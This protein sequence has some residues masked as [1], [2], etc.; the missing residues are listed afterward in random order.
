MN[1]IVNPATSINGEVEAPPSK[2][3]TQF[4][5]AIAIL[6]NGKCTIE[7]PLRVRDT[8]V[9]LKAAESLGAVVKRSQEKWSIW[10]LNG[11]IKSDKNNLDAKNSGTAICLLTALTTLSPTPIVLNGDSQLRSRPMP[12]FLKALRS[13]GADVYSTKPD[14]SP[15]FMVFGG[16]FTGGK[17]KL[18]SIESRYLPA[19]LVAAPYAKKKVELKLRD[20]PT[21]LVSELMKI[22][23]VKI[24]EKKN[25]LQI[26]NQAYRAFSYRIPQEIS[27]AAPFIVAASL[28]HS[29]IKI[30]YTGQLTYRDREFLKYLKS[31]GIEMQIS[32][33]YISLEGKQRLKAARLNLTSAPEFL[34]LLAVTACLAR[35]KTLLYGAESARTM[36]SDRIAAIAN[37]LRRMRA[38]VLERNDGL[39]IQGPTALRGC[40]VDGHS[41]YA[42]TAALVVAALVSTGAT[43]I[44]NGVESLLSAYSR[45]MSTFQAL[46]ADIRYSQ[47]SP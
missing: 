38:R 42:I 18:G 11:E 3:H 2:L 35:G 26:P 31:F 29:S 23:H 45:F 13:L 12:S 33:K 39:L 21:D 40:E 9:M 8:T 32:R 6:A 43:T 5:T 15:P 25:T 36:K 28:T 24:T 17:V 19:L 16:G 20:P 30:N 46:G 41:D 14:D 10:G 4:S 37:E 22:G 44:K 7:S 47:P 1:L 27:G 34:P